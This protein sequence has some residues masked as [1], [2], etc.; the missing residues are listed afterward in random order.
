MIC[1]W[2]LAQRPPSLNEQLQL[3]VERAVSRNVWTAEI[4]L[5]AGASRIDFFS[6]H[7]KTIRYRGRPL[8]TYMSS[9]YT[10]VELGKP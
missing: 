5:K 7:R 8:P 2:I 10:R 9:P 3:R 1:C 6:N 4:N